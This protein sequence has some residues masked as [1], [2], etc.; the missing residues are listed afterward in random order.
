MAALAGPFATV[1]ATADIHTAVANVVGQRAHDAAGNEY[2]YLKGVASLAAG[3][4]VCYDELGVTIRALVATVGPVAI[5]QAAVTAVTSFGWFLIR[6]TGLANVAS[7]FADNA[8]LNGTATPGVADDNL[9]A[10]EAESQ[11]FGAWGR[12]AVSGSQATVQI[13]Y[14][15]KSLAVLD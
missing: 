9:V 1:G 10:T 11:I 14:P 3:D 15:Y 6:G 2:I 4:W 7:G 13:Q 8:T 5:A 12:S